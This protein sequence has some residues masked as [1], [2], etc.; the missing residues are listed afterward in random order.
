MGER[1]LKYGSLLNVI[2][3]AKGGLK[4]RR[5]AVEYGDT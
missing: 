4:V 3:I 2:L 5:V 1:A